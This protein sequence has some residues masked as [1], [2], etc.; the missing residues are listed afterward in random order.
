MPDPPPYRLRT[1]DDDCRPVVVNNHYHP[2][3]ALAEL[4]RELLNKVNQVLVVQDSQGV[5]LMSITDDLAA[6][7]ASVA[8]VKA[9]LVEIAA[10]IADLVAR[11]TDATAGSAE[12]A[13]LKQEAADLAA[14]ALAAAGVHTPGTTEPP[15]E[16]A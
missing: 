9:A 8:E 10:D 1:R 2:D 12:A 14:Q 15:V 13:A 11:A 16:P 7:R 5:Q 6:S 3:P 4:L